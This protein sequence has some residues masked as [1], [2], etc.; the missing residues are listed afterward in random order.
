MMNTEFI[1]KG[2]VLIFYLFMLKHYRDKKDIYGLLYWGFSF[3][4]IIHFF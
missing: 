3:L 2:L 1:I 4:V